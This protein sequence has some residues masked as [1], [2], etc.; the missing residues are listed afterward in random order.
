[1]LEWKKVKTEKNN[2][3]NIDQEED[4]KLLGFLETKLFN[5]QI[6]I[7]TI[8]VEKFSVSFS[9]QGIIIPFPMI[10][11]NETADQY[12]TRLKGQLMTYDISETA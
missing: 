7:L 3:S 9:E 5:K 6:T 8:L 1:L 4:K 2:L 10:R 12:K 11:K